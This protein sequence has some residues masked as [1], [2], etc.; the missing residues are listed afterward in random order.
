MTNTGLAS[1]MPMTRPRL[2]IVCTISAAMPDAA[3]GEQLE[4]D[5][6]ETA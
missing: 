3:G 5:D 4:Q 1:R 6:A 2:E